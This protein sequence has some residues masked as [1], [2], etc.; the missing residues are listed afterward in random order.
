MASILQFPAPGAA[1]AIPDGNESA[2]APSFQDTAARAAALDARRSFIVEAPAG[3]GKT[4]LLVQRFLKLLASPSTAA[5]EEILAITFTRKATAELRERI[6]KQLGAAQLEAAQL[7][8]S[9]A[10]ATPRETPAFE[11]QTRALALAVLQRD[12]E[13]GWGL[14]ASPRRLRIQT[15]D[16]LCMEIAGTM[17]LL[18]GS[19]G[20]APLDDASEL[21]RQA[22]RNTLLQLGG[23]D[24]RLH[25]ALEVIL[26]HRDGNLADVEKLLAE[27]L[28][29]REQWAELLP[30]DR[31]SLSDEVL[32]GQV[33]L[34]LERTLEQVVCAGLSRALKAIPTSALEDLSAL[35]HSYAGEPGYGGGSNPFQLCGEHPGPPAGEAEHLDHWRALLGLVLTESKCNWRRRF[36][37]DHVKV[38]L[39]KG[40]KARL[41]AVI[42]SIQCEPLREA[43]EAVRCLP[44][45]RYPDDQW[46]HA[47]ALFRL[48]L[49]ALAELKLLFAATG[50][51]DFMEF[52]LAARHALSRHADDLANSAGFTLRHLLVDEMQDTSSAQYDLLTALTRTW[53]GSS[54]TLFLVGDPKQSIYL[55]RQARVERFLR[56]AREGSLGD[57]PLQSL[58]LTANFRSRPAVI[59][60]L[61]RD[62]SHLFPLPGASS[63]PETVDVPFVAAIA[64]RPAVPASGVHW[65]IRVLPPTP[66]AAAGA[67][68]TSSNAG[69]KQAALHQA[70][71]SDA[72]RGGEL[73]PTVSAHWNAGASTLGLSLAASGSGPV[74][75]SAEQDALA[76]RRIVERWRATPLPPDRQ[77]TATRPARPW[78]IAVLAAAR[79]HLGPIVAEFNRPSPGSA[80]VPYR[81]V[82]VEALEDR[83]EVLDLLALTRALHHPADRAAWFAVLRAPWCGL[84]A[85]D[86]LTLAA[87]GDATR[88]KATVPQLVREGALL[89]SAAG[90]SYLRRSWPT[91]LA[92]AQGAGRTAPATLVERT[93]HSLGGAAY[94]TAA[95]RANVERYLA[96]LRDV[97]AGDR[98]D[99]LALK[100]H[101]KQLFAEPSA[102][103][104]AVELMTIHGAK[105]L[106]WDVVIVPELGRQGQRDPARLLNWLELETGP[107]P[108]VLL[109]PIHGKG[110]DPTSL[111]RWLSRVHSRRL[112]AER[113]RLFYVAGTRAREELHFFATAKQGKEGVSPAVGSLLHA[114]WPAAAPH[115]GQPAVPAQTTLP[116]SLPGVNDP[117]GGTGL[118]ESA[119]P[120]LTLAAVAD[121]GAD[122]DGEGVARGCYLPRLARLPL[123]FD[124]QQHFREAAAR[125]LP[126]PFVADVPHR[127]LLLRPEGSATV[128]ALGNVVHRFLEQIARKLAAGHS[129]TRLRDELS[130]WIDRL[131]ASFRGEGLSAADA[132]REASRALTLLA[133]TLTDPVGQWLLSPH[134]GA[135]SERSLGT[136]SG[137]L[138]VDR[139]L[140]AGDV[141]LSR[142]PATP[143]GSNAGTLWV[144][145]FKTTAPGGRAPE[146][147][148]LDQRTA[149]GPQLARYAA[150]LHG[151]S[152]HDARI[153]LGLYFPAIPRLI[154]WPAESLDLSAKV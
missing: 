142:S 105:G 152:A 115:F 29:T 20:R 94:V 80:P 96:L 43:L 45:A 110:D 118:D 108:S 109:A 48:L 140:R 64:T 23:S 127:R 70:K 130:T 47:K 72:G 36:N 136:P 17:P 111:Y 15:I 16:S 51:C 41:Q 147:F 151:S 82:K 150:A 19:A 149:Y 49:H 62:S 52:S 91:L 134:P 131:A 30:L 103:D 146:Q 59:A 35:A 5:P 102:A 99:L 28:Q 60:G 73:Q 6:L 37:H 138:R 3:S 66:A 2:R 4:G 129:A 85:P 88:A 113:K 112:E 9:A 24:S 125:R 63:A 104:D 144:V 44:P 56:T 65:H 74:P 33:R 98:L 7:E 58:Q 143:P 42:D 141:P 139:I 67:P 26:L 27:M 68:A 153:E 89:L 77:V 21:Y 83:P 25:D 97:T 40:D 133:N 148:L 12:R 31:A 53:D 81:A 86:L 78:R 11:Q 10:E 107:D 79:S 32:D 145:D 55:F 121:L 132:S 120:G 135:A 128:R 92:A 38:K 106:E 22:A 13:S 116:G 119:L 39:S 69:G 87:E 93:W 18:S 61:N 117:A 1:L 154:H 100:R 101:L 124:P 122:G 57:V 76:I 34:C 137:M 54:Q 90:Q 84:D 95:E 126:Y 123:S 71:R 14:L 50:Q 46:R 75:T 8:A 114:C